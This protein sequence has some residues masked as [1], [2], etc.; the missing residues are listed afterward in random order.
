MKSVTQMKS[1]GD[2]RTTISTHARSTPHE[3]GSTYLEVY[4][5]DKEKQRLETEMAM[6]EKR[7]KRIQTRLNDIKEAMGGLLAKMNEE[8]AAPDGVEGGT[9][10]GGARSSRPANWKKMSIRY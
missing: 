3:K 2:M 10:S 8:G 5:L 9:I 4:L 1:L 6:L 7:E